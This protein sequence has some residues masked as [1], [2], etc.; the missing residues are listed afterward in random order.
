MAYGI[1]RERFLRQLVASYF[2]Q[3]FSEDILVLEPRREGQRQLIPSWVDLEFMDN[4]RV[5][6]EAMRQKRAVLEDRK[7][8][9]TP[10]L[11]NIN[12]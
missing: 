4:I 5:V 6:I 9:D 8:E 10:N 7:E 3:M 2:L 12:R 11:D 1:Q